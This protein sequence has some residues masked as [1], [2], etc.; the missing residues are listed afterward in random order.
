MREVGELLSGW[1]NFYVM[2]GSSAAALTGLMFVVITLVSD[3]KRSATRDGVST[4]STPTVVHFCCALFTSALMSA[5]F[6]SLVPIAIGLGLA[7]AGG[8]FHVARIA[9]R[10]AKL[11]TYR[12]D[13]EDWTWHVV[14]PFVAYATLVT[15][16]V[17]LHAAPSLSLYAPAAAVTL[18]IFVGIHNAW[19]VVTYLATSTTEEPDRLGNGGPRKEDD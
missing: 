9:L 5:P 12:P 13:A 16:A 3:S 18:L 11:E 19:D 10:T 2:I 8:L 1:S 15:G 4:F 17:S 6:R 14:L 7:G